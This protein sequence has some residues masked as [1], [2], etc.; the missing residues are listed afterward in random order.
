MLPDASPDEYVTYQVCQLSISPEN[1]VF[2]FLHLDSGEAVFLAPLS[3][4][5]SP[6]HAQLLHNFRAACQIM[7][8][9]FDSSRRVRRSELAVRHGQVEGASSQRGWSGK[10]S[11]PPSPLLEQGMLFQWSPKVEDKTLPLLSY[12]ICGRLFESVGNATNECYVCYHESAPQVM[13]EL[14]FKLMHGVHL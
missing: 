1:T 6:L 14:A 9:N 10:S 8:N 11:A 5:S 2:H 7:H 12:W 4:P 13:V 3:A